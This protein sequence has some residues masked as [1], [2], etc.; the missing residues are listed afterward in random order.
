MEDSYCWGYTGSGD[1]TTKSATWRAHD[2]LKPAHTSW[3]FNWIW[4]LDV[5]PKIR[6]FLWQ[7]CHKALPTKATLLQRGLHIDPVCPGCHSEI[8]DT[9]HLFIGCHMVK[10]IWDLAVSHNWIS[11]QSLSL[12]ESSVTEGLHNLHQARD[13]SI[14]R[15]ALLLWSVWKSRNAMIFANDVPQP[16]GSLIRAKRSWAE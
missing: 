11:S 10:K 5:M 7:L 16:M 15:I 6:I 2:N 13:Q 4:K 3:K 8:E 12:L 14:S 9:D 1:F